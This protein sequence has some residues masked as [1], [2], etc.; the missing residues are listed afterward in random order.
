MAKCIYPPMIII[1][2]QIIPPF[3]LPLF[4]K[5]SSRF[6]QP[7]IIAAGKAYPGT[8]R[9][10]LLD[11]KG[12]NVHITKNHYLAGGRLVVQ[13]GLLGLLNKNNVNC[14]IAEFNVRILS[15]LILFAYCQMKG[16]RFIWWG[17]GLGK[18]GGRLIKAIRLWLI[19]KSDGIILYDHISANKLKSLGIDERII[20]VSSNTV[21]IEQIKKFR[22]LYKTKPRNSILYVGRL[23]AAKKVDLLLKGFSK[24]SK[25]MQHK[26]LIVGD[27]A[28]RDKLENLSNKLGIRNQ[29][30]FA[31]EITQEAELSQYFNRSFVS[32]SPGYIGLS[33]IHSLAYGVPLLI[34]KDEPHSPEI[35]VFK[36]GVNGHYFESNNETSLAQML[37]KM[38]NNP[39]NLTEMGNQ[40][41]KTVDDNYS[42]D[43]MVKAFKEAVE[44]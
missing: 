30:I 18:T 10:S 33:A 38:V 15:N 3:R 42:I 32:V 2:Q 28:E 22:G 29:T 1:V 7:T 44:E 41:M 25:D 19:K 27:G 39:E 11:A 8:D 40:G 36:K 16:I 23:T 35:S 24:V 34:A 17:H 6:C 20:H 13:T 14:V 12:I 37:T 26:L 4:R 31:G 5:I 43:I 21:D 9:R